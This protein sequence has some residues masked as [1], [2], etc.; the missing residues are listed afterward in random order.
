MTQFAHL[1]FLRKSFDD[2]MPYNRHNY[3]FFIMPFVLK[4]D[5]FLD[6][7]KAQHLHIMSQN[8]YKK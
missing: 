1:I 2:R 4:N 7:F 5:I 8:L 6:E 3:L